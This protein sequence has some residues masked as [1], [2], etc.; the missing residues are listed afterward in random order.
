MKKNYLILLAG[1]LIISSSAISQ[2]SN[3]DVINAPR[4][5][6]KVSTS[7]PLMS[8]KSQS[9]IPESKGLE[10][11][12]DDFS[13][14]ATWTMTNSSTPSTDFSIETN[15]DLQSLNVTQMP[16]ELTPFASAT[17]SNGFL[18]ISSDAAPNNSDNN[19][20]PIEVEATSE[21]IDLSG[22]PFVTLSF[23][24]NYR[25]WQDERGVR[26]SGDNGQ[27]WTEYPITTDVIPDD[28][29][30][31]NPDFARIDI[32]SVAGNSSQVLIQ[33][34]YN[35][36]DFWGWYWAVDDV[37]INETD[38]FDLKNEGIYWGAEGTF[39]VRVP[40]Y[41]VPLDQVIGY[42]ISG[43]VENVGYEDQTDVVYTASVTSESFTSSSAASTVNGL[44]SDSLDCATQF[45]P[46][47]LGQYIFDGNVTSG[48]TDAT[49]TDNEI[50]SADSMVV[51]NYIYARD[52]GVVDGGYFPQV[53]FEGGNYF[54]IN[55]NQ[56]LYGID[57]EFG[58]STGAGIEI[59]GRLYEVVGTADFL[60]LEETE[61]YT[62]VTGDEGTEKTL[63][64]PS[65]Q[66]LNAGSLYLITVGSFA[67]DL[68]LAL[69][70]DS[71]DQT[72]F[73]FGDV[74]AG[75]V[76]WYFSRGTY[77]VRM[78]FD[79]IL[80]VNDIESSNTNL[81]IYPN[82]ANDVSNLNFTL[83]NTA[84]VTIS[85]T[86]LSGK[87]VMTKAIENAPAGEHTV[88][89]ET[90]SFSNGIYMVNYTAGNAAVTKKLVINK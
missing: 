24:H 66:T 47:A 3:G 38:Q 13:D 73:V 39:G 52:N 21:L 62:T 5:A 63:V 30:T 67:A 28:Q 72:T 46:P 89:L 65:K 15:T 6:Q 19:G 40:Y 60:F 49:P 87:E 79:P 1:S 33:F 29:N 23:Q 77:K 58:A 75:G 80:N 54:D 4:A 68:S 31:G 11:W 36:N 59:Y 9:Q 10:L 2:S 71:P 70:G 34:Y 18:W 20:T 51:T 44:S 90:S 84:D 61:L 12:S 42:D 76:D 32:S 7:D 48:A 26:V 82:P 78:N 25:W 16:A 86:D 37:K 14:P 64:F 55:Q 35:D 22:S 57:F 88:S 8:N 50:L 41:Q 85:V 56:D 83:E 27:T 17:G 81:S 45:T 43:G 53:A 69:A 74:G